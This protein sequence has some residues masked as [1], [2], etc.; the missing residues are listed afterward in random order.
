MNKL[1]LFPTPIFDPQ[2]NPTIQDIPVILSSR[3]P[4]LHCRYQRNL[5]NLIQV[6]ITNAA[7]PNRA[8]GDRTKKTIAYFRKF[9]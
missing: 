2:P 6:N 5:N 7:D 9:L 1:A 4:R 8:I 3:H